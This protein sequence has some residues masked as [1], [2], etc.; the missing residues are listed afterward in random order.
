MN[1]GS[2]RPLCAMPEYFVEAESF[3]K[4]AGA[5]DCLRVKVF[6]R[7]GTGRAPSQIGEYER[8]YPS[9]YHT[10]CPFSQGDAWFALYSPDYTVTRVMELPSCRDLGGE[11]PSAAGFCPV[12]YHVPYDEQLVAAGV[13]GT[14]GFVSG[15]IWGDD[16]SWKVE[17]L[18]LSE[19]SSGRVLREHR[20]GYI[21]MPSSIA[22]LRDCISFRYFRDDVRCVDIAVNQRYELPTGKRLDPDEP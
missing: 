10:F 18:D 16:S 8:N 4:V 22:R 20:F 21:E 11:D 3:S 2:L 6:V 7:S 19:A 1:A 12:D 17:Y 15:C 14:V 13:A 9:L 5:W